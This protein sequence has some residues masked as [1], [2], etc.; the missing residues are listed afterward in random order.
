MAGR[1]CSCEQGVGYESAG[2]GS[3]ADAVMD[4]A[5]SGLTG[6]RR[7]PGLLIMYLIPYSVRSRPLPLPLISSL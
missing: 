6:V 1:Y 7:F 4:E 3:I 5:D 2:Y